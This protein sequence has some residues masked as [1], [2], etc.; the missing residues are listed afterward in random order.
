V[1]VTLSL[2]HTPAVVVA[3][4]LVFAATSFTTQMLG[5]S[6]WPDVLHFRQL[7][8]CA[9][10]INSLANIGSFVTPYLWGAAKDATG[11]YHLGLMVLPVG[12]L[13]A[14]GLILNLR[15]KVR[16]ERLGRATERPLIL[17]AEA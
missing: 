16:R 9:A 10:A 5:A 11:S 17:P 12:Y 15:R 6:L 2:V 3:A 14:A 7:A 1:F 8:V 13:V 4:Y